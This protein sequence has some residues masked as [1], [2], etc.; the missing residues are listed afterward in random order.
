MGENVFRVSDRAALEQH[1]FHNPYFPAD[2]VFVLRN[3]TGE[4]PLAVGIIVANPGYANPLQV[5]PP[6]RAFGSAPLA[7]RA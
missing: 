5:D 1:L 2:S 3:R 6:C 4:K 7:P